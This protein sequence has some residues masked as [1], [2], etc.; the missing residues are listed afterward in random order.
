MVVAELTSNKISESFNDFLQSD[1]LSKKKKKNI[2]ADISGRAVVNRV[3]M[4]VNMNIC[5]PF[6]TLDLLTLKVTSLTNAQCG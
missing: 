4:P 1:I 3:R 5:A 6:S 2:K